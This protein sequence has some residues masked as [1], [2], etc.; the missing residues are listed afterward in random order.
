MLVVWVGAPK[1][2]KMKATVLLKYGGVSSLKHQIVD[3]P[4]ELED[5]EVLVEVHACSVNHLDCQLRSGTAR[6]EKEVPLPVVLG[7]D[8]SGVVRKIGDKVHS[9]K[10]GDSIFG[11]QTMERF[12][13]GR[14]GSCAEWC[15][16]DEANVAQKPSNITHEHAAAV[17]TAAQVAFAALRLGGLTEEP[18][19][20]DQDEHHK[21]P[22][23]AVLGASGGVGT[24]AVQIAKKHYGAEV[25]ACCSGRHAALVCKLGADH[26]IDYTDDDW[27]AEL[28][29][30]SGFD[31]VLDCVGLDVYWETFG[32]NVLGSHGR[33]VAL[34]TLQESLRAASLRACVS[35]VLE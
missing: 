20:A 24:F 26:F 32:R 31:L 16:V 33:Y 11:R 14:G 35:Y 23:V 5:T 29:K 6:K 34:N 10:V 19:P 13:Q 7:T 28:S 30:F 1:I 25:L 18:E 12:L 15:V 27:K 17:P 21:G 2:R 3:L 4:H 8:F 22:K 9:V